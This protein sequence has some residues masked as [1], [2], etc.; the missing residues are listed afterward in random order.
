MVT[1]IKAWNQWGCSKSFIFFFLPEVPLHL[2]V[3]VNIREGNHLY[4]VPQKTELIVVLEKMP[5]AYILSLY[6]IVN[7]F[8][9]LF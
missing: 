6:S 8:L 2:C 7:F 5:C 4:F 3:S 9:F 1:L